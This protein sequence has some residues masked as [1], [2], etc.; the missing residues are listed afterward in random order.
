MAFHGVISGAEMFHYRLRAGIAHLIRIGAD[1][2]EQCHPATRG[3]LR[4]AVT[5]VSV[6]PS[7]RPESVNTIGPSNIGTSITQLRFVVSASNHWVSTFNS[8]SRLPVMG[9]IQNGS[10]RNRLV[11]RVIPDT[12]PN[13]EWTRELGGLHSQFQKKR[14]R[15]TDLPQV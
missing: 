3:R 11:K 4:I 5:P 6:R 12:V 14:R 7:F 2:D 1:H 13:G 9:R 8:D 10:S 15:Q